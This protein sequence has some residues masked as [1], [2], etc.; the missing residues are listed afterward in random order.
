MAATA[1]TEERKHG[2]DC[3]CT[4]CRGFAPGNDLSLRHGALSPRLVGTR[5]A[6]IAEHVAALVP[7]YSPAS[8]P[9]VE[10][11]ARELARIELADAWLDDH[12]I[13][14][15]TGKPAGI[16]KMRSVWTNS[17]ARL[18][19]DLALNPTA[20]A[21]LGVHVAQAKGEALRAHLAG[22]YGAEAKGT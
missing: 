14:D 15:S 9:T 7:N 12:G 10:L 16:L 2:D 21:R 22:V 19:N 17:A 20:Q 11:L 13:I 3:G 6:E 5:A 1:M 18:A 8:A 4:R